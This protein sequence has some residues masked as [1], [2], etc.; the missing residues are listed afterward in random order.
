M[1]E[2]G[3]HEDLCGLSRWS[4][5]PYV[6]GRVSYIV[7]CVLC[8]SR[9]FNLFESNVCP[10]FYSSRLRQLQGLSRTHQVVPEQLGPIRQWT[11]G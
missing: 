7:V 8:S 5:I 6:H 2:H 11:I 1:E 3:G 9:E 10:S 4:V